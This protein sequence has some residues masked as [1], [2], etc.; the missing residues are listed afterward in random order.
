[1]TIIILFSL[2]NKLFHI[3]FLFLGYGSRGD[4]MQRHS[5]P[6]DKLTKARSY[7]YTIIISRYK[8]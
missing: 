6:R 8:K 4:C 2:N 7:I 5:R 1:M 3:I